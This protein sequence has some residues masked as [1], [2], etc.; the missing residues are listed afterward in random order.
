[1]AEEEEEEAGVV[2]SVDCP[3]EALGCV[4][5]CFLVNFTD[6]KELV[7]DGP[8]DTPSYRDARTHLKSTVTA[9]GIA[10]WLYIV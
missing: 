7:I 4:I 1:M 8:T 9:E 3:Y 10:S 6:R 5:Y 2:G